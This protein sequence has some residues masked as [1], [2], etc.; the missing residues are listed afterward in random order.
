MVRVLFVC[1][2]NICRSPSAE[3]VF[4][5]LVAREG[6]EG[7]I[8][9]DSAG[10]GAWHIGNPPDPRAQQVAGRYGIAMADLRARQVTTRDFADFDYI[11]GMDNS[12]LANLHRLR[13]ESHAGHVSLMLDFSD[14]ADGEIPDPYY[15][16]LSDY[17][18]VFELLL[19]AARGLLDHIRSTHNL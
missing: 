1:L 5:D 6:L 14:A 15:G 16:D 2:G 19:P 10:T 13:P 4:R 12:N 17:E 8:G 18:A 11:L 7:Q 3:A 9:T